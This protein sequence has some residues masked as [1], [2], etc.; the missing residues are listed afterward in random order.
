MTADSRPTGSQPQSSP[1]VELGFARG[2]L[3]SEL[4]ALDATAHALGQ[5]FLDAVALIE[6]CCHQNG[7]VLVTGLGKSGL[8]GAKIS[9]TLASLGI[10]SHSV[11]PSEAAHGDLGKFQSRDVVLA[12][13]YS[14]QTLEV[15]NLCAILHQDNLPI[16]ALVGSNAASSSLAQLA[17][18]TV[19]LHAD[20]EAGAPQFS[21]PTSS[22]TATM[23]VGD[24]LAL[25]VARRRGFTDADFAKRHPGGALGS[26]LRPVVDVLRFRVGQNVHPV[27][28]G[29]T[30]ADAITQAD[31]TGRRPGAILIVDNAGTLIGILT[32]GDLR[33]NMVL[34][35]QF[36]SQ[37]VDVF[38]TKSP[39]KISANALVKDAA[40]LFREFRLDDL[41]VVDNAGKPIG[42]LDIQDLVALRLVS[43]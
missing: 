37:P 9:A 27:R 20:T 40:V 23:A 25:T 16:I 43:E 3:T 12:I 2:V 32:D 30:V 24:A 42:V 22:T 6:R 4:A 5:S 21:A 11:H 38:M 15:V 14:G 29:T 8:V 1:E 41:P 17:S 28:S 31:T 35:Q 19:L 13:S 18:A 10:P 34:H 33:R 39:R 36:L 26:T 7:T